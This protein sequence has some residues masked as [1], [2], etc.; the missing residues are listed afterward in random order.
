MRQL[1]LVLSALFVAASATYAGVVPRSLSDGQQDLRVARELV[2]SQLWLVSTRRLP[3]GPLSSSRRVLPEF[4]RY[5]PSGAWRQTSHD[6]LLATRDERLT[7]VVLVHGN[8]TDEPMARSRGLA[9]YQSL[10]Q[11]PDE[12]M[13]LI[14]WSWPADAIPGTFRQ[15]ARVKA[16]R[17]EADSYYLA[18][19]ISDLDGSG[20][21]R[22]VGY[23]FGARVVTGG[24]HLLGGGS[25]AGRTLDPV[26]DRDHAPI[27]AVLMAAAVDA[28]WLLPGR[29]HG[30]AMSIVDRMVLLVNPQDR[31][32]RW[33]RFITPGNGATALGSN[34]IASLGS[35]GPH[36]QKVEQ[37]N[38]NSYIGGQHGWSSYVSAPQIL[39]HLKRE[40]FGAKLMYDDSMA[41]SM[42]ARSASEGGNG[43][44]HLRGG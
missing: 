36:R 1:T 15:D 4:I 8:D 10:A 27:R 40:I 44:M 37:V 43:A 14:I 25:L 20:P 5:E 16:E 11:R 31:A 41:N 34:G 24:L 17:A 42:P 18:Q 28:D 29:R 38:V 32:L 30:R 13:R 3:H 6:E 22:L 23:S 33:Y 26:G 9:I 2:E 39:D 12:P 19:F 7:T 35:L 21:V